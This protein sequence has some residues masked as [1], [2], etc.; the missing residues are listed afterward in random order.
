MNCHL[1]S[2]KRARYISVKIQIPE[3]I[4]CIKIKI[5][6]VSLSFFESL[7]HLKVDVISSVMTILLEFPSPRVIDLSS[8]MLTNNIQG[9]IEA[10]NQISATP[11][12]TL[13]N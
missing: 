1:N 3:T 6:I 13:F 4:F 2:L 10:L 8:N 11:Q 9:G 7:L 12:K 5:M